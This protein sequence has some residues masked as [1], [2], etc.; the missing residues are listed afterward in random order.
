MVETPRDTFLLYTMKPNTT[1]S[2]MNRMEIIAVVA[3]AEL[4]LGIGCLE[5]I[6]NDGTEGCNNKNQG[7]VSEDDKELFRFASHRVCDNLTDRLSFVAQGRKQCAVIVNASK[8]NT[9][10]EYP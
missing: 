9:A 5:G 2:T 7:Q 8:E 4:A 3:F 1:A 10:D 6:G